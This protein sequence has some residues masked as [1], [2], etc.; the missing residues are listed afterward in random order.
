LL[1]DV[2]QVVTTGQLID[3][4]WGEGPPPRAHSTLYSYVSRLRSALAS[5]DDVDIA[6]QS[7]GYV[8]ATDSARVDL[9]R[10]R[11]LV[12]QARDTDDQR[13]AV[14][15]EQA[16]RLW[17]AQA[18]ADL[19]TPWFN[20]TRDSLEAERRAN[21]LCHNDLKLRLGQ[22][23]ELVADL[24]IRTGDYPLDERLAGQFMLALCRS[25]RQA[26]ALAHYQQ[27]RQRLADEL[28]TDPSSPLR[29]LH[30][31][32]LTADPALAAPTQQPSA[33]R[34]L[35]TQPVPDNRFDLAP[36]REHHERIGTPV[37]P[38]TAVVTRRESYVPV[39]DAFERKHLPGLRDRD[40][41]LNDLAELIADRPGYLVVEAPMYAGKTALFTALRRRLLAED[42]AV[43]MFFVVRG[44]E[45]TAAAF[46]PKAITQLLEIGERVDP[47][48]AVESVSDTIDGRRTQF[49]SLWERLAGILGR[50]VVLLL[51]ALDEQRP[52]A[53]G[54]SPPLGHLLPMSLGT[55]GRVVVS[56]RPHPRYETV[57]P[58]HHP[59]VDLP[60]ER[61]Y[62][63]PPSEHALAHREKVERDL[64]DFLTSGDP[65]A[66]P[67]AGMY[68]LAP[69]AM[70]DHELA[71]LFQHSGMAPFSPGRVA[72]L[73]KQIASSLLT[74]TDDGGVTRFSLGH[75]VLRTHIKDHLGSAGLQQVVNEVLAWAEH[76]EQC[77]WPDDTPVFLREHVHR[78]A[79]AAG[80]PAAPAILIRLVSDERRAM[81]LRTERHPATF[82]DITDAALD[83]LEATSPTPDGLADYFRV[84]FHNHRTARESELVPLPVLRALVLTGQEA[85]AWGIASTLPPERRGEGQTEVI[86]ALAEAS[87]VG[88]M[89]TL[90]ADIP[91]VDLRAEALAVVC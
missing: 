83:A 2:N 39:I 73:R 1:I 25:G 21:E 12:A 48:L 22:H 64:G 49:A 84:L 38:G 51:D 63:L 57:L 32:I 56:T 53:V 68:A 4:V 91:D 74:V 80:G 55:L 90:A 15:Y 16:L 27:V 44:A 65:L 47:R 76:Y 75:D 42:C 31:Q 3:R 30:Q 23:T 33:E 10:F 66:E 72:N 6:N 40:R 8:L 86:A 50:P 43:V 45:D 71:D 88:V 60:P 67:L 17:R 9:H 89:L 29:T 81:H 58:S 13:A 69:A 28:G 41:E 20:Q 19:D 82:Q 78:F 77:S 85:R 52:D 62:L 61:M 5:A 34:A 79:Q 11:R 14:L 70:S 26:D 35:Q 87:A 59:L 46:L 54:D 24:S 37:K 18:F 36:W 7:G